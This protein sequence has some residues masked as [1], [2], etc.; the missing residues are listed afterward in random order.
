[1]T[2]RSII[3]VAILA[4]SWS[5]GTLASEGLTVSSLLEEVYQN[6]PRLKAAAAGQSSIAE[7]IPAAG[8]LANPQFGLIRENNP[9]GMQEKGAMFSYSISQEFAWPSRYRLT[10][11][12]QED[13]A[14]AARAD[15][16]GEQLN[17]RKKAIIA[18]YSLY[19]SVRILALIE[20]QDAALGELARTAE[21]G[22]A[23]GRASQQ[24]EMKAH[25]EQTRV[26]MESILQKQEI[27]E[28]TTEINT[29]MNREAD[30]PLTLPDRDLAPPRTMVAKDRIAVLAADHSTA[31]SGQKAQLKESQAGYDL[32][33]TAYYPTFMIGYRRPFAGDYPAENYSVE[34]SV[35]MP[36]WFAAKES[37]Q[38]AA[39][40]QNKAAAEYRLEEAQRDALKDARI[41]WGQAEALHKLLEIYDSA[42]I[43]QAQGALASAREA[44]SIGRISFQEML[45]AQRMVIRERIEYYRNLV[46]LVA[47]VANLETSLGAA[48][49]DLPF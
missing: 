28:Q 46:K 40:A 39:A 5:S 21:R 18:Y 37:A 4:L 23:A 20:T 17:L 8:I 9:A 1:M 36:L 48:V 47:S 15:L 30:A 10:R 49:S 12:V 16:R 26:A 24:D 27:A 6:N 11:T 14:E 34:L 43:P 32:A 38:L 19:A 13:K 33:R 44:Y 3:P 42:L 2:A 29:L 41:L 45:D 7:L 25:V 31:V 22:R 35:S